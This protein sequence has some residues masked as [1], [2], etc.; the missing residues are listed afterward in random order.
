ME[1]LPAVLD[2]IEWAAALVKDKK[3]DFK[4]CSTAVTGKISVE[5]A[6]AALVECDGSIADAADLL[7]FASGSLRSY[8]DNRVDLKDFLREIQDGN[9][10]K[11]ER[12]IW[13]SA[14]DG[15]QKD[16]HFIMRTVGRR[17]GYGTKVTVEDE[18]SATLLALI[19]DAAKGHKLPGEAID[20]TPDEE[21]E[22]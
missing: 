15:D 11:I 12:N 3:Y 17:R 7:K 5:D 9:L 6:A 20:I 16:A 2:S 8:V 1:Q 4:K 10:D 21:D 13:K 22:C 18:K 14:L 19:S